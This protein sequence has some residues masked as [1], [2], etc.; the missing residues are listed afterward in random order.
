MSPPCRGYSGILNL[1]TIIGKTEQYKGAN[2]K[3]ELDAI[4]KEINTDIKL[5][6]SLVSCGKDVVN[7]LTKVDHAHACGT[8]SQH[9]LAPAF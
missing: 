3:E 5:V 2:T 6:Q 8:Y 4:T 9:L 7:N 1:A